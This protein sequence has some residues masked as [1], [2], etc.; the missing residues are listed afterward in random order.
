MTRY[1]RA[2]CYVSFNLVACI[3]ACYL[4]NAVPSRA[5]TAPPKKAPAKAAPKRPA[6]TR[7]AAEKLWKDGD[8]DLFLNE[9]KLR[10]LAF[11]PEE[12]WVN[13]LPNGPDQPLA[14]AELR[15]LI[16]PGPTPEAVSAQTS[17]L[18]PKIKD[19]AQNR[20][21]SALEALVH[22]DLFAN[23]SAVY[24]LFDISNYRAFTLGR[25]TP[26]E[27]RRV[28]VQFFQLTTSQVE[29][30]HYLVFS[31]YH[32]KIVLRDVITGPKVADQFLKDEREIAKSK[33][34]LMFRAL[35]DRDDSGLKNLCTPGLY[36][37][38]KRLSDGGGSTL[39]RGAYTSIAAIALTPSVS[40]DQKSARV[41][42]RV[43]YPDPGNKALEY[44]VDFERIDKDLKVV[45]VRDAQ[46]RVIAWDPDIDNY[47]SRRYGLPDGEQVKTVA[48]TD[49][50]RFQ[51]LS[52]IRASITRALE[53]REGAKLKEYATEFLA[54]EPK[55]GDGYGI[56]AAAEE[57][58]GSYDDAAKDATLAIDRGGTAYFVVLRH[59]SAMLSA[60][61][62]M[63][64]NQFSPVILGI[65]KTKIEYHAFTEQGGASEE[66]PIASIS[67]SQLEKTYMAGKPR[68]FL[69]LAFN[70]GS[71]KN[72]NFA[73]FGT[74]C[75]DK[76]AAGVEQ[77]PG[78]SVCQAA[79]ASQ[80]QQP[81]KGGFHIPTGIPGVP[82]DLGAI[83][84][85]LAK[86]QMVPMM[87][88][89]NWQ[90]DLKVVAGAIDE[91]R[92]GGSSQAPK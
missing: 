11:E 57:I 3:A 29:R 22:P 65:S 35:N 2:A 53:S 70:N 86:G 20:N 83:K 56:R 26:M 62:V 72:Y 49:D 71:Q 76:P 87:V 52:R 74:S 51:P 27:S 14:L 28:G 82:V 79:A 47:L 77:Y 12:D 55:G 67:Q 78:G 38:L 15:K 13:S 4:V 1:Q 8:Q 54:R 80:P 36:E 37:S 46:G 40:L 6:L 19:A 9:L 10:G 69:D 44:D 81:K 7:S 48:E 5:Q 33:L 88:P 32:G 66:I 25:V 84:N 58:L 91:A 85:P 61:A 43:A 21:E 23:K 75:P 68:P 30:L 18:L 63:T 73:S 45:R 34:D 41:V 31:N 17:V 92:H 60:N 42:V 16:P 64:G 59:N 39:V 24:D 50:P 90:Q 89:H